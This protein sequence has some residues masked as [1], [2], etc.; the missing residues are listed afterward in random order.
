[1]PD[2]KQ[3][4]ESVGAL[5]GLNPYSITDAKEV[6]SKRIVQ[7]K[8]RR[9]FDVLPETVK[10]FNELTE[11]YLNLEKAKIPYPYSRFA[12]KGFIFHDLRRTT[13]TN[14]RK[15]G[16]DKNVRMAWFGH[17]SGNDMDFR[18]DIVDEEDLI[19]AVDQM[20]SYLENVDHPVYQ[21]QFLES[22]G[23]ITI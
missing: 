11:W 10:T 9:I 6:L 14:A 17:S 18:Y 5:E 22:K 2:G 1:M 20:E 16:V 12:E 3:K 8:E 7:K 13:K 19:K 4:H 15:S 23:G 21:R